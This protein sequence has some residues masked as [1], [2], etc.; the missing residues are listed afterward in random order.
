MTPDLPVV[1]VTIVEQTNV[2]RRTNRLAKVVRNATLDRAARAYA[3]YLANTGK[4]SHEADGRRPAQRIAAAGYK[5]CQVAENL[6][7]HGDS[8]GFRSRFLA[9]RAVLDWQNSPGHRRNML[10]RFATDI[11]VGVAKAAGAH[12]YVSVQLFG[13]PKSRQFEF[14][15]R[16]HSKLQTTYVY[17]NR[18]FTLRSRTIVTH[19]SC[20]PK[21][22]IFRKM[23]WKT[24]KR[25]AQWTFR[26]K[27][28][29]Q[30]VVAPFAGGLKVEHMPY[31]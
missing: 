8:R 20:T 10:I 15:I 11:G 4:F 13:R 30:F 31:P 27:A 12:R 22:L 9:E 26:A 16:N 25:P 21:N 19:T 24:A 29:D 2:F 28:G 18:P 6:A 3:R 1:E 23:Y 5:Y 14:E 7:L 17:G